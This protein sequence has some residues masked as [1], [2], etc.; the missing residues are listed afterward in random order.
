MTNP[1]TKD[2]LAVLRANPHPK[3]TYLKRK[4]HV[5][6]I[7]IDGREISYDGQWCSDRIGF[8]DAQFNSLDPK[9]VHAEIDRVLNIAKQ[10]HTKVGTMTH[11]TNEQT[12]MNEETDLSGL[13]IFRILYDY[14]YP[15]MKYLR[16]SLDGV[17]Q[18][19]LNGKTW[20]FDYDA[21]EIDN[22]KIEHNLRLAK[23]VTAELLHTEIDRILG[24]IKS[25]DAEQKIVDS[26][27]E[28]TFVSIDRYRE[29][30]AEL[31]KSKD[32][33]YWLS[34][35]GGLYGLAV[36]NPSK[37]REEVC[38]T[39]SSLNSAKDEIESLRA[40]L[41]TVTKDRDTYKAR[42]EY[43]QE[44]LNQIWDATG[45]PEKFDEPDAIQYI[46]RL[47]SKA[48]R[49]G[50]LS[51]V[52]R[53]LC[54]DENATSET[55]HK[56]L[57][58]FDDQ[59]NALD[60]ITQKV[61]CDSDPTLPHGLQ[62]LGHTV[63][64]LVKSLGDKTVEVDRWKQD[65]DCVT[66]EMEMARFERDAERVGNKWLSETIE[67]LKQT[68]VKLPNEHTLRRLFNR[69]NAPDKYDDGTPISTIERLILIIENLCRNAECLERRFEELNA[70]STRIN[71]ESEDAHA[72]LDEMAIPRW[73]SSQ[74]SNERYLSLSARIRSLFTTKV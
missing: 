57:D 18:F 45:W 55:V 36:S 10:T 9:D 27:P 43:T 58:L 63:A 62:A 33:L 19:F 74:G 11:N 37:I 22:R 53:R 20:R 70:I 44:I 73:T 25:S 51:V 42:Q 68:T 3:Q 4:D 64:Q 67:D 49:A 61:Q 66:R 12:T 38:R 31:A 34:L 35:I 69:H 39:Y 6:Y 26:Q 71:T 14:H 40:E 29:L 15:T 13:H 7:N 32:Q 16:L 2:I 50:L 21:W 47:K 23:D 60:Y 30:E 17:C 46:K 28:Q 1:T 65:L 52:C 54:G 8:T 72:T 59:R 41:K 5:A 48:D 56:A 24:M